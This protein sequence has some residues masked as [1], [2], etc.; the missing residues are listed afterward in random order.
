MDAKHAG[1]AITILLSISYAGCVATDPRWNPQQSTKPVAVEETTPKT[2]PARTADSAA[3]EEA[4]DPEIQRVQ[5]F[6]ARMDDISA[7]TKS[8]TDPQAT[9]R[10][11]SHGNPIL[12]PS[13]MSTAPAG[14]FLTPNDP[15]QTVSPTT[16]QS[17]PEDVTRDAADTNTTAIDTTDPSA[18]QPAIKSPILGQVGVRAA[19]SRSATPQTTNP[20]QANQSPAPGI[21]SPATAANAPVTL[22]QLIEQWQAQPVDGSY[23][24]QLDQRLVLVLAGKY[25]DA[26]RPLESVSDQ[27]QQMASRLIEMLIGIRESHGGNPRAEA[28]RVLTEVQALTDSLL[29]I[30]DPEIT[31]LA[32]TR[33]V[34][35]FGQYD[36]FDPA[37]F[38][39]GRANEFVV[40]SELRN[41]QSRK[42]DDGWFESEFSMKTTILNRGGEVILEINDDPIK[43]RCRSRRH[44]C[45]IPRLV[46]LPATLSPGEYVVKLTIVDKIGEKVT[47]KRTT[48]RIVARS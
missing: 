14:P 43:D 18:T 40:Y 15:T 48:F 46:R 31:T 28:Q 10:W 9:Q 7:K 45:F 37:D 36:L 39:T 35:G 21:N 41:F 8:P 2:P 19:P 33:A 24:Q 12:K 27:Q 11:D 17:T 25:E 38:P 20:D 22:D 13:P 29:Q 30:S 26:R 4:S 1:L 3:A 16:Q 34:R 44:D 32:L 42:T 5:Q 6:I 47:E 23:R